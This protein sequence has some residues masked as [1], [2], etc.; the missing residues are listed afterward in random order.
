MEEKDLRKLNRQDLLK[1]LL[2]SEKENRR[3]SEELKELQARLDDR[4][5]KISE[6]GDIAKA[7]LSL[8][9]VFESAQ[10]AADWYL[11]SVET[12]C[13][14]KLEKTNERC[15]KM[16]TAAKTLCKRAAEGLE[17]VTDEEWEKI[18]ADAAEE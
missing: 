15:W 7:A 4:Q 14:S 1:L 11:A 12:L 16:E 9:G 13:R 8:S 18:Y 10:K 2:E 6:S 5:I 3:L 17:P